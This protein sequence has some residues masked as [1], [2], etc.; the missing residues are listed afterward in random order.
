MKSYLNLV[1]EYAKVHNKKNRMT[2]IC[3]AIAVCLV[4]AIFGMADMEIITRKID[5]IKQY[6][7]YHISIKGIDDE[8]AKLIG[9]RIDVET[10]GWV[11]GFYNAGNSI[12]NGK[13]LAVVGGEEAIS[14]EMGIDI[15]E[16]RFPKGIEECLLD[17]RAIEQFHISLGDIISITLPDGRGA[18]YTVVGVYKDFANLK[19]QDVHGLYLSNEGMHNITGNRDESRYHV[20]FKKGVN[21]QKSIDEIKANFKLTDKQVSENAMLL[22]LVGQSRN[23][24]M[25]MLYK[26]AAVLF[27]LVLAAGTLM[28]A[29]S[30]NMEVMERTQ[31]YGMLSCLGAS[32]K[33]IKR[34]V[35]LQGINFSLKGIPIGL[36][37][38]TIIIWISSA[39]LKYITPVYFSNMPLFGISWLSLLAGTIVGFLTVILASFSP[40]KKA[41]S[42]SPLSAVTGNVAQNGIHK[43]KSIV[44]P[45][46]SRIDIAMG[47]NHAF[48]SRKNILLM[49]GSFGISI[50]LFLSFSVLV[51]FM[52][53][54]LKP[55]RPYTPDIS[56]ISEDNTCL[57][58]VNLLE[59][60]KRNPDIKRVYGRMF[61]YDMSVASKYGNGK[62]NLISYEENQFNWAKEKLTYGS[63]DEA[64]KGMD[65]VLIAYSEDLNYEVGD[66]I[67]LRLPSSEKKVKIAGIL[68][69]TPFDREDGVET[70][71]CSE[72]LFKDLTGETGYTII[73][74]QLKKGA[75]DDTVSKIRNLT[76]LQMKFSDQRQKNEETKATFY[77]FAIFI[78]G[79]LLLIAAITVFN[80]INSINMSVTSRM[81]QYGVMRAVG[82]SGKQLHHL[83][84]AESSTYAVCGCLM[85]CILGLPLYR[86]IYRSMITSRWGLEWELPIIPL[87]VIIVIA[88][89]TTILSVISPVKKINEMDIVNVV[90]A[91]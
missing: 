89:G 5:A 91:Q 8:T 71:I 36:L 85:G 10:S 41:S 65:S 38:G 56:I 90:N 68:S 64:V 31:F 14:Y 61:A 1:G 27:V 3:I 26:T 33:Q 47:I 82:M 75:D 86:I 23:S 50:V 2:I 60:L 43:F 13:T 79:F 53:Q 37:A 30:F 34:I 35:L 18:K 32:K 88:V 52:H 70:V 21:M 22:G 17:R 16:G 12:L 19:E 55:L 44:K 15:E 69:D 11:H 7:N 73:D 76:T 46:N 25:M 62:I 24:Y 54:A 29:S 84:F 28:I 77:S 87:V 78:Y 40:C 67:I 20:Q 66:I 57:L 72:R 42:V 58:D 6:G 48:A 49:T 63:I 74:V 4:T 80:I 83:V 59:E 39:F 45:K 9:N 51:N 81:N